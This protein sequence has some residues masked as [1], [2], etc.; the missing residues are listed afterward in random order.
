MKDKMEIKNIIKSAAGKKEVLFILDRLFAD[1]L[2]IRNNAINTKVCFD[3]YFSLSLLPNEISAWEFENSLKIPNEIGQKLISLNQKNSPALALKLHHRYKDY[4]IKERNEFLELIE[5][6]IKLYESLPLSIQEDLLEGI[7]SN[8]LRGLI[9]DLNNNSTIEISEKSKLF[10]QL[11][12]KERDSYVGVSLLTSLDVIYITKQNQ[13]EMVSRWEYYR[14]LQLEYLK[15]TVKK[16]NYIE[17]INI[18]QK[19]RSFIRQSGDKG[20]VPNDVR[21]FY[22]N[23]LLVNKEYLKNNLDS[24]LNHIKTTS[25]INKIGQDKEFGRAMI[26]SI[27]YDVSNLNIFNSPETNDNIKAIIDYYS[28]DERSDNEK[29]NIRETT[30]KE[31]SELQLQD[32]QN[33]LNEFL[34][35]LRMVNKELGFE[36]DSNSNKPNSEIL[37]N[38]SQQGIFSPEWVSDKKVIKVIDGFNDVVRDKANVI[39]MKDIFDNAKIN[40]IN[41][42]N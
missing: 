29:V 31:Y 27:F 23:V 4:Q 9:I 35:I 19:I 7:N 33:D 11:L 10:E 2:R 32:I 14:D 40:I 17:V 16:E 36:N 1:K 8:N 41:E 3:R 15:R 24:I 38:L 12:L 26:N 34:V 22:D 20:F 28:N 42:I 25:T 18:M 39:Y 6:L 21:W 30:N 37:S 5:G 13:T